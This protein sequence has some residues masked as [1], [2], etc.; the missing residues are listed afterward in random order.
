MLGKLFGRKREEPLKEGE[1]LV[2]LPEARKGDRFIFEAP[3]FGVSTCRPQSF[4]A[5]E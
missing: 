1:V 2:V 3:L 4:L 5:P